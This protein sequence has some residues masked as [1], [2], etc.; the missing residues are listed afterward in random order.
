[1]SKVI[2]GSDKTCMNLRFHINRKTNVPTLINTQGSGMEEYVSAMK[3]PRSIFTTEKSDTF[4]QR[5]ESVLEPG[6]TF[7]D[8]SDDYYTEYKPR[9]ERFNKKSVD[10]ISSTIINME[11]T[12]NIIT[13]GNLS[14]IE[15]HNHFLN[16]V[17]NQ[18]IF[19]DKNP[20]I[21]SFSMMIHNA[22]HDSFNQGV[23]DI[24]S[25]GG[26]N[27]TNIIDFIE[28]ARKSDVNGR[29]LTNFRAYKSTL[30]SDYRY[31]EYTVRNSIPSPIINM[32][33]E[34]ITSNNYK[35]Y[36]DLKTPQNPKYDSLVALNTLRFLYA[37]VILEGLY[38]LQSK[39]LKCRTVLNFFM[40]GTTLNCEMLGYSS[41]KLYNILD[42]TEEYARAFVMRCIIS[43]I[44]CPSIKTA[45]TFYDRIKYYPIDCA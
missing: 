23:F 7:F 9:E 17:F 13:S 18:I 41:E 36:I 29:I 35:K 28:Y 10:Y 22:M 14:V 30:T 19:L 45:L 15:T 32:T 6:D 3:T 24:F 20:E 5:I 11:Y 40:V 21:C 4:L 27:A 8:F 34:S 16:N 33:N 44:P 1:M 31:K 26:Q 39:Y 42:E 43:G 25:Y 12:P 38:V 2:I 37:S